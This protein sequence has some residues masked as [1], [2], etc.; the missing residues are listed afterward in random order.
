M[1]PQVV[2]EEVVKRISM[3]TEAHLNASIT[4]TLWLRLESSFRWGMRSNSTASIEESAIK[5]LPCKRTSISNG[6]PLSKSNYASLICKINSLLWHASTPIWWS[7][8]FT[9]WL[10]HWL[11]LRLALYHPQNL[12]LSTLRATYSLINKMAPIIMTIIMTIYTETKYMETTM[13]KITATML[14]TTD[15]FRSPLARKP[16]AKKSQTN[17]SQTLSQPRRRRSDCS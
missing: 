15:T 17:K 10:K 3:T 12:T 9:K 5:T 7:R 13:E 4:A 6:V 8:K 1:N 11:R 14:R 2:E 16:M